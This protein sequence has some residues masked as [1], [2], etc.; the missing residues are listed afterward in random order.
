MTGFKLAVKETEPKFLFP[1]KWANPR[2]PRQVN[3][4]GKKKKK[5]P[6]FR[7]LVRNWP[8]NWPEARTMGPQ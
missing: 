8:A 6:G 7:Y 4:W 5:T 1:K 3:F 2:K